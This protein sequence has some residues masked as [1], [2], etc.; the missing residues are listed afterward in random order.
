MASV[1]FITGNEGLNFEGQE[2]QLGDLCL[3]SGYNI[4]N[5]PSG[6]IAVDPCP[7]DGSYYKNCI[8]KSTWCQQNGYNVTSCQL[9]KY[10][11]TPCPYD[12][13]YYKTCQTDNIRAC[14]ELGYSLTCEDGKVGDTGDVCPY[15]SSYKK[16]IC[17]PCSG[18]DYAAS[19]ATAQGYIAGESCNS[20]G[21]LKY[22]RST[23]PCDGYFECDE[24]GVSGA[25]VCYSGNIKK[26]SECKEVCDARFKYDSSNCPVG[27]TL[28]GGVCDGKYEKCVSD[29]KVGDILYSD[30][31][32]SSDVKPSKTPIGIVFDPVNRLAVS[33]DTPTRKRCFLCH[34]VENGALQE[35]E[36]YTPPLTAYAT[37]QSALQIES[38]ADDTKKLEDYVKTKN[39]SVSKGEYYL[40]KYLYD[41]IIYSWGITD[42]MWYT[43]SLKELKTLYNNKAAVSEGFKKIN[44]NFDYW[45]TEYSD[46]WSSVYQGGETAWAFNLKSGEI[47][48]D[49]VYKSKNAIR[50]IKYNLTKICNAQ[51]RYDSSNCASGLGGDI[52]DGKYETCQ[53]IKTLPFLYSDRTTSYT[54]DAGGSKYL[55]GIVIDEASRLAVAF[56]GRGNVFSSW[57]QGDLSAPAPK[58]TAIEGLQMCKKDTLVASRDYLMTCDT[59]GLK[60]TKA[61]VEYGEKTGNTYP[62]FEQVYNNVMVWG[63]SDSVKKANKSSWFGV[64]KWFVPSAAQLFKFHENYDRI[65]ATTQLIPATIENDSGRYSYRAHFDDIDLTSNQQDATNYWTVSKRFKMPSPM[66]AWSK[67]PYP[68]ISSSGSIQIAGH[69][70]VPMIYY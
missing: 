52:C 65:I 51:Y 4:K 35:Y 45:V 67:W 28:S 20:C 31:T 17:N 16:C 44:R 32:V 48:T 55:I 54:Y 14:K 69:E 56:N 49:R 57:F 50:I 21:T 43:P 64:G 60:N 29:S 26:F 61:I 66:T 18:Y 59:D 13:N 22:K 3:T 10:P 70:T 47:A 46:L 41:D 38:G 12:S 2:F 15:N 53:K 37:E 58:V 33:V 25:K 9:P 7:D 5:C 8:D 39:A 1:Y 62:I 27:S 34:R 19:E 24:G 11:A 23:N 36:T 63:M 40:H 6:Y 68:S 30:M 42:S